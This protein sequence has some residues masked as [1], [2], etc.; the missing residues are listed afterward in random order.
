[1]TD[2]TSLERCMLHRNRE[3]SM[4][5]TPLGDGLD[6]PSQARMPGLTPHPPTTSTG[7]T[8]IERKP[9]EV[10]GTRTFAAAL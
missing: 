7:S 10:E 3:V 2:Q 1:M 9:K 8:P 5:S 6:R 4:A